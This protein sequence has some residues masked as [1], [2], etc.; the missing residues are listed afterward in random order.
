MSKSA[1]EKM[2]LVVGLK[3]GSVGYDYCRTQHLRTLKWVLR[4]KRETSSLG[5]V[6]IDPDKIKAE[7][8]KCEVGK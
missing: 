6:M 3:K 7:I 1:F 5:N 8:A 2:M 4:Q